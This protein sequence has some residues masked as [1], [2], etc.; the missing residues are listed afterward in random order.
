MEWAFYMCLWAAGPDC[1]DQGGNCCTV[2][3][4]NTASLSL[5]L[6]CVLWFATE[7]LLQS[8][9]TYSWAQGYIIGMCGGEIAA[10]IRQMYTEKARGGRKCNGG[11]LKLMMSHYWQAGR[12]GHHAPREQWGWRSGGRQRRERKTS[13]KEK[14]CEGALL[15]SDSQSQWVSLQCT[16]GSWLY[17][18]IN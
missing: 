15:T 9:G 14:V 11:E 18:S 6:L 7:K 8:W 5:L 12:T 17:Q 2:Q 10:T 13:E 1:T 4:Q 16:R 3:T